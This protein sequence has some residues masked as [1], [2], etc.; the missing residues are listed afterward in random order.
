[1]CGT[2]RAEILHGK[3]QRTDALID[4][5]YLAKQLVSFVGRHQPPLE[6][7]EKR[8]PK[9]ILGVAQSLADRRLRDMKGP[10]GDRDGAADIHRMEYVNF[11]EIHLRPLAERLITYHDDRALAECCADRQVAKRARSSP[12]QPHADELYPPQRSVLQVNCGPGATC[13]NL[14]EFPGSDS[15]GVLLPCCDHTVALGRLVGCRCCRTPRGCS[16]P[17]T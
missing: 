1:M 14:D 5:V 13:R 10:C 15:N 17:G 16:R 7:P 9:T 3:L 6:A 4:F 8:K 11:S 2:A 12:V